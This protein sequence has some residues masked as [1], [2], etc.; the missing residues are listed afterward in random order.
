MTGIH[1]AR[2]LSLCWTLAE[3]VAHDRAGIVGR[4]FDIGCFK[5]GHPEGLPRISYKSRPFFR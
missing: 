3:L 4:F 2:V 1:Q 5:H